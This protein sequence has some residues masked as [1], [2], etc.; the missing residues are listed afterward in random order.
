MPVRSFFYSPTL[1]DFINKLNEE[2]WSD[3]MADLGKK[4]RTGRTAEP[5]P[6][7]A[8]APTNPV[9]VPAEPERETVPV[10]KI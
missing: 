8:F 6:M 9:T 10:R 2:L 3:N 7:P 1:Q 5:V 4:V